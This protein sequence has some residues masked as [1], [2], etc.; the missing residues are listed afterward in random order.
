M[1][2]KTAITKENITQMLAAYMLLFCSFAIKPTG[3]DYLAEIPPSPGTTASRNAWQHGSKA[4]TKNGKALLRGFLSWTVIV[5]VCL[6]SLPA[7]PCA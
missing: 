6:A 1:I 2:I 4:R 5:V 7:S 3:S